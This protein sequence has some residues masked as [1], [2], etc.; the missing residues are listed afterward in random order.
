M[1]LTRLFLLV[2]AVPLALCVGCSKKPA[3]TD[4]LAGRAADC[5]V[6][7]ITMDTTRADYLGCY[8]HPGNL[9][10]VL[11]NLARTGVRF[12][13]AF[14]HAPITLTA[15]ASLMTG[16]L[17]PEHG[18]RDN[19]RFALGPELPTLAEIFNQHGYRTGA[20]VA[21]AILQ[22]RY[23][24]NRGFENY[25]DDIPISPSGE[26]LRSHSAHSMSNQALAW[27]EEV[28]DQRFFCWV[29]YF[30]PH[31]PYTPPEEYAA[32][33]GGPYA[34][35]VAF[36]D[37]NIGRL[38]DWLQINNLRERTLV[39]AVADHGEGLGDH[40]Y[41]LHTLLLNVELMHVPLIMSLPGRLPQN[42][43]C[44]DLVAI[45]D[46]M[47][48]VLELVGWP[49]PQTVSGV[50]GLSALAGRPPASRAI[51]GE[52][53]YPFYSFGWSALY[54]IT[55]PQ[56]V[57]IRAPR[58]ELYDRQADPRQMSNVAAA[59]PEVVTQLE[60]EL[61]AFEHA[62]QRRAGVSV[63][64]DSVQERALRSLGYVGDTPSPSSTAP[65][66]K[67]PR[68]MIAVERDY[69]T[70][71][72]L[73][74]HAPAEAIKLLEPAA[75]QS[76]ESFAI[77]HLLG[78][79][80]G[81]VNR[82]D[83]S[84]LLLTQALQLYPESSQAA[85]DLVLTLASRGRYAHGIELCQQVLEREPNHGQAEQMLSALLD[86]LRRQQEGIAR[87]EAYCAW[88]EDASDPEVFCNW[89][90]LLAA[91]G[92]EREA[93]KVLKEAHAAKPADPRLC[94]A[95]AWYQST[96][97]DENLRDGPRAL[98]LAEFAVRSGDPDPRSAAAL[99]AAYAETG[100]FEEAVRIAR[101]I[102]ADFPRDSRVPGNLD[103][104]IRQYEARRPYRVLP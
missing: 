43:V 67:N 80:Y 15:H 33:A 101:Q 17:P 64:P 50:S 91:G 86:N 57:Y 9:T 3:A 75:E 78:N 41:D 2:T 58:N 63:K 34:G 88:N 84:Q 73:A 61:Q 29:H 97:H 45:S 90:D 27:L 42:V 24:L 21:C 22:A 36:M 103:F 35:E 93:L 14:T 102:R 89:A 65:A 28:R 51:Y 55:T 104:Q 19:T 20:F 81:L 83:E 66:L 98:E 72:E 1:L 54:S 32:R 99:A 96:T 30:D 40:G 94:A 23:G 37:A 100:R 7:L 5:N 6:L 52:T 71:Q 87:A 46:I 92:R 48:T 62:V 31:D 68:D 47:P 82:L 12:S 10:P 16:T 85:L 56:W 44:A 13:N 39:I 8:G 49:V 76:P 38:I 11:D 18:V 79:C 95:L 26:I 25:R 59:R 60:S 69:R 77:L 70:A 74:P 4:K 53:E